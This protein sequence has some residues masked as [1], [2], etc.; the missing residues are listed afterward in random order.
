MMSHIL[1]KLAKDPS[2]VLF[3][4]VKAPEQDTLSPRERAVGSIPSPQE[5]AS[6]LAKSRFLE[7]IINNLCCAKFQNA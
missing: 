6:E 2:P 4:L 1:R 7:R 5:A 3:R